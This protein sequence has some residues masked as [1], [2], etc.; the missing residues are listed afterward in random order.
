MYTRLEFP[1][2][3]IVFKHF[4]P[5]CFANIRVSISAIFS[6]PKIVDRKNLELLMFS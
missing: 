4:L 3:Y 5:V 6:R 1:I 2:F